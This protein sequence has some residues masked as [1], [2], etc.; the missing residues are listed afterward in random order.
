MHEVNVFTNRDRRS[1]R[2]AEQ[3]FH[4]AFECDAARHEFVGGVSAGIARVKIAEM[5]LAFVPSAC[6]GHGHLCLIDQGYSVAA[7]RKE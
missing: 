1:N 6:A 3:L 2:A 7:A 4:Q 5:D